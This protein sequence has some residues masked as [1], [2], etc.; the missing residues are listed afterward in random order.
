MHISIYITIVVSS[1]AEAAR[2]QP[3]SDDGVDV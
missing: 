2:A 1:Q 3:D